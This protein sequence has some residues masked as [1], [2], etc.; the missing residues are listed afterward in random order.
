MHMAK[1]CMT[2]KARGGHFVFLFSLPHSF[3][4]WLMSQKLAISARLVEQR[5]PM[6]HP[7][8]LP[9]HHSHRHMKP[10]CSLHG[11]DRLECSTH[12]CT[13]Q[14]STHTHTPRTIVPSPLPYFLR[15]DLSLTVGLFSQALAE[16][17]SLGSS[18]LY[19]TFP[20]DPHWGDRG[21]TLLLCDKDLNLGLLVWTAST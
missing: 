12:A 4:T 15:Q 10:H 6:M 7:P 5:M 21:S 18:C 13:A 8:L 11:C 9:Q 2:V 14:H 20:Y 3:K 16:K 17:Q 19:T 1:R